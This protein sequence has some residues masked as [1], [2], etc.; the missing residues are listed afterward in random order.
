MA[1]K[2]F[3][4]GV[5]GNLH[6]GFLCPLIS[7]ET[8]AVLL[9][10]LWMAKSVRTTLK[11]SGSHCLLV[12]A[13]IIP[14]FLRW[15]KVFA[16]YIMTIRVFQCNSAS[17]VLLFPLDSGSGFFFP[18]LESANKNLMTLVSYLSWVSLRFNPTICAAPNMPLFLEPRY[19]SFLVGFKGKPRGTPPCFGS[20]FQRLDV[21]SSE[22]FMTQNP[23]NARNTESVKHVQIGLPDESLA[24]CSVGFR[25]FGVGRESMNVPGSDLQHANSQGKLRRH[26]EKSFKGAMLMASSVGTA[27]TRAQMSEGRSSTSNVSRKKDSIRV[28]AVRK[29]EDKPAAIVPMSEQPV[30]TRP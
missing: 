6:A 2:L 25:L 17:R 8:N 4:R 29:N 27:S 12:F 9:V 26:R 30:L 24:E 3:W 21:Q 1:F 7:L 11:T 22:R 19:P 28:R 13:T 20:P 23:G 15:C 14:G 10:L 16:V 18:S 5:P